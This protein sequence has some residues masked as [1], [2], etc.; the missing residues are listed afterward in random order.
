[1]AADPSSLCWML[2][3]CQASP[4]HC[5]GPPAHP[6]QPD[7]LKV[8]ESLGVLVQQP[9]CKVVLA[10][11]LLLGA[12]GLCLWF[13]WRK[14]SVKRFEDCSKESVVSTVVENK[15]DPWIKSHFSRLSDEK[16]CALL[17][18]GGSGEASC[19]STNVQVETCTSRVREGRNADIHKESYVSRQR[20]SGSKVFKDSHRQSSKS[21]AADESTWA[22]VAACVREIDVTGRRLADSMLQ[23]ATD[24]NNSGHLESKDINKEELKALEEVE[25]K[26]KGNFLTHRENNVAGSSSG[27]RCYGNQSQPQRSHRGYFEVT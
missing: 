13:H 2:K 20:M 21:S 9:S 16:L 7:W 24:Y 27:H 12:G 4:K 1:M 26:V 5:W 18:E 3:H 19:A 6:S 22:S 8:L 11:S 15:S 10:V 14:K 25:M 23:R 17:R